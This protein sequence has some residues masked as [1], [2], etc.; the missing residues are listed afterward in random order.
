[1]VT[2]NPQLSIS[3]HVSVT[4]ARYWSEGSMPHSSLSVAQN[5][6][7]L[8]AV[9]Q[10]NWILGYQGPHRCK[11]PVFPP[12]G[13]FLFFFPFSFPFCFL[14]PLVSLYLF[15]F[16]EM[17]SFFNLYEMFWHGSWYRATYIYIYTHTHTH[18]LD[19]VYIYDQA[20]QVRGISSTLVI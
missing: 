19:H 11:R 10:E 8:N 4:P 3:I 16:L 13:S 2:V 9:C 20:Q 17:N 1:M 14:L 15:L 6:C 18:K 12:G 7:W 5:G